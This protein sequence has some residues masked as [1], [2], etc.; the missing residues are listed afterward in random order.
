MLAAQ[1]KINRLARVIGAAGG[2]VIPGIKAAVAHMG[3]CERWVRVAGA[4]ATSE[5]IA[6]VQKVV[7]GMPTG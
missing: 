7:N 3:R 6:A 4:N 2:R 5:E 1:K